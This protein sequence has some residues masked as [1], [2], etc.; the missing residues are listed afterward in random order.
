MFAAT[1]ALAGKDA[2]SRAGQVPRIYARQSVACKRCDSQRQ[3][4]SPSAGSIGVVPRLHLAHV[5]FKDG[6]LDVLLLALDGHESVVRASRDA[7]TC[8]QCD[9][10]DGVEAGGR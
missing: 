1:L 9:Q 5:V 6:D 8:Q 3:G 7:R 4:L 2:A 10:H